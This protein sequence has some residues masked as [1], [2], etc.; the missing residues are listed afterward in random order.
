MSNRRRL[1]LTTGILA[2]A[3]VFSY[4][5]IPGHLLGTFFY[6]L[7]P[8]AVKSAIAYAQ[9]ESG[10]YWAE[11]E[12]HLKVTAFAL[13]ISS[14]ICIPVGV[15]AARIRTIAVGVSNLLGIVRG[16]P[17]LAVLFL[18]YPWLGIGFTPALV[19]LTLLACPPIFINTVVAYA[20]VDRGIVE[21]ARGMGMNQAQVLYSI[22]TP[23]ALP[24]VIA[25]IRTAAIE[26]I[27][28]ATIAAFIGFPTLGIEIENA[29]NGGYNGTNAL[30][31]GVGSIALIALTA[32]VAL[33]LAQRALT[34]PSAA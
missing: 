33:S 4:L 18:V 30:I 25:G 24:V 28:S 12:N 15:L 26:V 10:Q 32:E 20:G 23:L 27:A 16:I 1:G 34:A 29:L 3:A 19:A 31:V 17:S 13:C 2:V 5:C 6:D 14:G 7:F 22:E 21:A 11:V 9:T 8:G